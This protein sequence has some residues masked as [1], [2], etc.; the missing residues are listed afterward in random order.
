MSGLPQAA[1]YQNEPRM[2]RYTIEPGQSQDTILDKGR[3]REAKAMIETPELEELRPIYENGF[4]DG[5]PPKVKLWDLEP[6]KPDGLEPAERRAS[7]HRDFAWLS[8][9]NHALNA[10]QVSALEKAFDAP[11][12]LSL[13]LGKPRSGKT[14]VG[15]IEA[16]IAAWS[17]Y[18]VLVCSPNE[19]DNQ[20]IGNV[21][22]TL[23]SAL[24]KGRSCKVYWT[25]RGPQWTAPSAKL[26]RAY[27]RKCRHIKPPVRLS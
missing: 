17:G 6:A 19:E 5:V 11:G 22:R 7:I 25:I 23:L 9:G 20:D 26:E 4:L 3:E 21:F 18:R 14:S 10:E 13:I 24:P 2:L 1:S 16:L 15:V 12:G 27:I 8:Q